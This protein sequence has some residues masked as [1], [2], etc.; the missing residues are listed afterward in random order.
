[1]T[2]ID[3][4]LSQHFLKFSITDTVFAVPTHSPKND[5]TDEM[6]TFKCIHEVSFRRGLVNLA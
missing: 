3:T 4:A 5:N 2:Y 6:T 1:M